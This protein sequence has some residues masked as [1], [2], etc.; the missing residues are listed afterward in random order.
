MSNTFTVKT[1]STLLNSGAN[2]SVTLD[3]E[4]HM[5]NYQVYANA[6]VAAVVAKLGEYALDIV[7][8]PDALKKGAKALTKTIAES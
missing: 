6:L 1:H 8:D 4:Q 2:W 5:L 7:N 3:E